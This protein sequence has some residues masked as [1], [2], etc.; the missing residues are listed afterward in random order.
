MQ[1]AEKETGRHM[2]I[3]IDASKG[4]REVMNQIRFARKR[5]ATGIAIFSFTDVDNARIWN[6]LAA[7]LFAERA[8]VPEMPWKQSG[9]R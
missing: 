2:Y 4:A 8:S 7:D 3:G 9:T 6:P 1:G 5:G